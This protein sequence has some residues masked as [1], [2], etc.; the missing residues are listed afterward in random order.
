MGIEAINAFELPL[1]NTVNHAMDNHLAVWVKV[2]LYILNLYTYLGP[3]P[4]FFFTACAE[5]L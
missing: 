2:P 5:G 4:I 1:L 3:W